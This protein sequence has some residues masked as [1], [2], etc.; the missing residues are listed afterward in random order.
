MKAMTHIGLVVS[1]ASP[2]DEDL[3][4]NKIVRRRWY[5]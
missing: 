3:S 2:D 5:R 1:Y 4:N